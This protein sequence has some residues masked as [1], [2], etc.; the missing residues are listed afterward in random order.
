M[1]PR[2]ITRLPIRFASQIHS[3]LH[4]LLQSRKIAACPWGEAEQPLLPGPTAS[5]ARHGT[6]RDPSGQPQDLQEGGTARMMARQGCLCQGM[7][8]LLGDF[9]WFW[10]LG[11]VV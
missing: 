7:G 6:T 11:V 2:G 9:G 1:S 3:N 8:V 10:V 4:K 5:T